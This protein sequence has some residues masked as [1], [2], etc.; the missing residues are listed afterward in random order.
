MRLKIAKKYDLRQQ[1][2]ELDREIRRQEIALYEREMTLREFQA[3]ITST[4]SQHQEYNF[5]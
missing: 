3:G 4:T 1:K 5:H 2:E